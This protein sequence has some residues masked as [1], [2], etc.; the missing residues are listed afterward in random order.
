[1]LTAKQS[2]NGNFTVYKDDEI[3]FA[4]IVKT[5]DRWKVI[6][7]VPGRRSSRTFSVSPEQAAQKYFGKKI[8]F[9]YLASITPFESPIEN[10]KRDIKRDLLAKLSLTR[11]LWHTGAI[12][13]Q[14]SMMVL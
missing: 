2:V 12:R 13:L 3:A 8:Q 14:R 7:Q 1:M 6:N 9:E 11:M 5:L 10:A 4:H